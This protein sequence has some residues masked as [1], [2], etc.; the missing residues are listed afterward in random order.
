MGGG[1]WGEGGVR[2][3]ELCSGPGCGY[4]SLGQCL[5]SRSVGSGDVLRGQQG[6]KGPRLWVSVWGDEEGTCRSGAF[7]GMASP[8]RGLEAGDALSW[9]CCP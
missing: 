3:P 1:V 7:A 8:L 9:G 4:M 6:H 5:T 2:V